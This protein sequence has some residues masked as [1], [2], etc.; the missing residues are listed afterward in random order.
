MG[1]LDALF[2]RQKP[3]PMGPE[4]L[5][6][7]STAQLTL[8]TAENLT[9]AGSA[10]LCF[11]GVA[12]GPFAQIQQDL[13]QLL[14]LAGRDDNLSVKPFDDPFNYRWL[15]FS[16]SNFQALVTT[17]HVASQTL[18][19]Q[20]YGSQLLFAI[21]RYNDAQNQP[22]YWI[23][24]YKRGTFYPFVPRPDS[25]NPARKRDNAEEMRLAAAIGKELP[26]EN[27]LERWFPV[28]DLPL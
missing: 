7:M 2:G 28:W 10:A 6:A 14:D 1:F 11:K 5:F 8:E 9:A 19:D 12:S 3:V 27:E 18:I 22:I 20:G 26:V 17:L 16:G 24:N 4:K 23:Y 25:H 15:I 13:N 21:F